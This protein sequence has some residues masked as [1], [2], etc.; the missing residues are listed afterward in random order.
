MTQ[1]VSLYFHIHQPLRLNK[2]SIY[3]DTGKSMV[4]A[5]FDKGL[6][7]EIFNRVAKKC[8]YPTTKSILE[9]IMELEDQYRVAFSITGEWL[10]FAQ[11][12]APNIIDLF[13]ALVETDQVELLGETYYHSLSGLYEDKTEF[14]E[15][16]N[17][18]RDFIRDIFGVN[19]VVF[20]NTEAIYDN[21]IAHTV[22]SMGFRG[23]ITE[24]ANHILGG[25]SANYLYRNKDGGLKTIL[26]N[27]KLSDDIAFRFSTRTW[28][29][30]PL[31]ADKFADWVQQTPGDIVNIYVDYETFGEH[32][33]PETG[34]HDF[35][36]YLPE[37]I[38]KNNV[39]F[40]T[41]SETIE[42]FEVKGEVDVPSAI[43]WADEARDVTTWLGS[44]LQQQCFNELKGMEG[45]VKATGNSYLI[46]IW[47]L[48]Q[49]S[50][51][52]YYLSTKTASD[53]EVHKYF[54]PY[55]S[56]YDAFINYVNIIRDL[57]MR[58]ESGTHS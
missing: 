32:Q 4:D 11:Q 36:H 58:I 19:P 2:F 18:Q 41:P 15:Q 5:Y 26:R 6:N 56:P 1:W 37:F 39:K 54:S 50:D 49:T 44:P 8:Y 42:R 52:L 43:S 53:G 30:W 14:R 17:M 31:T 24:G 47:R 29:E 28:P 16:V 34:I 35:L 7:R 9:K 21:T 20:R 13:R 10:G 22:E 55:G 45:M 40:S 46:H 48:L 33:W 51:H 12:W 57:K 23:I 25:R 38:L 3:H 27:F